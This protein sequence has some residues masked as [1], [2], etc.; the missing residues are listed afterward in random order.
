MPT[1]IVLLGDADGDVAAE[2]DGLVVVLELQP[3][4][5]SAPAATTVAILNALC[6]G[7]PSV[8]PTA[9]PSEP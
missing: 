5:A 6:T 2:V 7:S 1:L 4:S 3:A 9:Q 8:A